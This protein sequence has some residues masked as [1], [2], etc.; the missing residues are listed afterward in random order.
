M[1]GKP[2]PV[3]GLPASVEWGMNSGARRHRHRQIH[4]RVKRLALG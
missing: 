3:A 4:E 2:L 1:Q